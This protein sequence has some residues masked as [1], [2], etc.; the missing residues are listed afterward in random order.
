MLQIKLRDYQLEALE[1]VQKE[2][3]SKV[4]RQ[5]IVLPTGTGKTI[6]FAAIAKHFNKR[7]LILAHRD[8]LI[9]QAVSKV[10]LYWP[11]AD[12]GIVKADLA[13]YS[14]QIVVGS[15]Q[16]CMYKKR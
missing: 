12:I 16:S 3:K 9:Q 15:V 14:H 10:K 4:L 7:T 1:A 5:L 8:E 11:E 2:Y 13:E 6:I